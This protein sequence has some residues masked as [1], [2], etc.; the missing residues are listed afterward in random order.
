VCVSGTDVDM[1][2]TIVLCLL[3]FAAFSAVSAAP[4]LFDDE[5]RLAATAFIQRAR[6]TPFRLREGFDKFSADVYGKLTAQDDG[7]VM[8]SPFR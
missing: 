1:R 6:R 4:Q 7:N 5:Q 2:P 3:A 8:Y